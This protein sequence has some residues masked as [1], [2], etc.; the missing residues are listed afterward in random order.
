MG[1]RVREHAVLPTPEVVGDAELVM[2]AVEG[3]EWSR[4]A[5][6][7]R[8]AQYLFGLTVRLLRNPGEAE[9]LVQDTFV[10]GF[11]QLATLREGG[12]V[13]GWLARIAVNLVSRRIRRARLLRFL[14]LDRGGD[15]VG[16]AGLA[17]PDM[18]VDDRADLA[19]LDRALSKM[20]TELRI[21]WTL[22]RV[23]GLPIG[24]VASACA[25]SLATVKRRIAEADAHVGQ[26]A[27]LGDDRS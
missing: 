26:F 23:E 12:A 11:A 3:D 6:Y 25:C 4:E 27:G 1:V 18:P 24:D 16:L 14:G 13:R 20:R 10:V 17:S 5:L 21:A 8:H 7:R 22:R 19:L 15:E 9:E 2:R